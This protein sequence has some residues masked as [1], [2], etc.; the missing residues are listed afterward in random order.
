MKSMFDNY[1]GGKI[2]SRSV[3]QGKIRKMEV[4]GSVI[5]EAIRSS[6]PG[7]RLK[8]FLI[9]FN[10]RKKRSGNLS[11]RAV[12]APLSWATP[13]NF[14][15]PTLP[16]ANY[17]QCIREVSIT[18]PAPSVAVL[19]VRASLIPW[20]KPTPIF[21][22]ATSRRSSPTTAYEQ[23]VLPTGDYEV[24]LKGEVKDGRVV[25]DL[26]PRQGRRVSSDIR[27]AP[28]STAPKAAQG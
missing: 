26:D 13:L 27:P 10:S 1:F 18:V 16:G 20:Q 25:F 11:L 8:F 28:T 21:R 22:A 3:M 12:V 4:T 24:P 9:A 23:E 2:D 5:A 6:S 19:L 7:L 15:T 14:Q 17:V